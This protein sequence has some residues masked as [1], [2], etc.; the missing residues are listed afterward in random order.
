MGEGAPRGR[1][2]SPLGGG[3][4]FLVHFGKAGLRCV[5]IPVTS[6]R[7]IHQSPRPY[8]FNVFTAGWQ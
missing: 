8:E 5:L 1:R 3:A 2:D 4:S 7:R 6:H